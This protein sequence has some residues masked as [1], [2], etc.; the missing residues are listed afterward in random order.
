VYPASGTV[1]AERDPLFQQGRGSRHGLSA[2]DA[3]QQTAVRGIG[4]VGFG[5]ARPESIAR[6]S[7][8]IP[9]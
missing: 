3:I 4:R 8:V 1:P 7:G 9:A 6:I 5:F 2:I